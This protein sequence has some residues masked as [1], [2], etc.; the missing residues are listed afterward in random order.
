VAEP[1]GVTTTPSVEDDAEFADYPDEE[2][3][4]VLDAGGG[5]ASGLSHGLFL[6]LPL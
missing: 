2:F 5:Y 3:G 4:A 1:T 6:V